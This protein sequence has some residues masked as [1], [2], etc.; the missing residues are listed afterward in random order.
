MGEVLL[1]AQ[2]YHEQA[3]RIRE[4]AASERNENYRRELSQLANSYDRLSEKLLHQGR[5]AVASR[6]P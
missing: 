6:G 5:D 1:K 3:R 2:H 4:L